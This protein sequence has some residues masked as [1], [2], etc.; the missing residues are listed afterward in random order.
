MNVQSTFFNLNE[1]SVYVHGANINFL[2][3]LLLYNTF[4]LILYCLLFTNIS[5]K[6]LLQNDYNGYS[7]RLI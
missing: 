3:L 4:K 2:L 5:N 7:K 1:C 6:M